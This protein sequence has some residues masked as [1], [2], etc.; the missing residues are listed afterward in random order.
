MEATLRRMREKAAG[1][2][3][4]FLDLLAGGAL[5]QGVGL[6]RPLVALPGLATGGVSMDGV[7]LGGSAARFE[8]V[9][10]HEIVFDL[11]D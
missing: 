9:G 5:Q 11:A 2:D 7:Q 6:A 3:R 1:E 4:G 8:A 10:E